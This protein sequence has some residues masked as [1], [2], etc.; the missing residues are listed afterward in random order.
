L[1]DLD[2]LKNRAVQLLDY[3]AR[4]EDGHFYIAPSCHKY[5]HQWSWDSSFHAI[6]NAR[7][8]RVDLAKAEIISLL[9]AMTPDGHL[10]HIIFRDRSFITLATRL[11][12]S[13][14][15]R[16]GHSP[17]L[18]PPVVA[19]AIQEV[20]RRSEDRDFLKETLPLLE[21]HFIWLHAR[22]RFG[23]SNLISILSPWESGLDHKP[24]FDKL[25]GRCARLPLGLYFALYGS[26]IRL[27]QL[28]FDRDEIV[29]KSLFNVQDVMFN[30]IYALGLDALAELFAV[31]DDRSKAEQYKKHCDVVENDI[32]DECFDA[33][34][35]LYFDVDV[36]SGKMLMNPSITCLM[37]IA[38]RNIEKERCEQIIHHLQNINEFWLNFPIPSVPA[39]NP[40]F[41]A[42]DQRYL[43]RGPT[44][45]NTNWLIVE[46][47]R[48]HGYNELA[49]SIAEKSRELIWK[50]G[51]REYY[52]PFTGEGGGTR[53]FSWSTLAA[54]M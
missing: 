24:A 18:Q 54:V 43:W 27:I 29:K 39:S 10:P 47:L 14:W 42:E 30:T 35:G 1:A 9:S 33:G 53:D 20:W 6:V 26:E 44:W 52:N 49:D 5:P 4:N 8:G 7:L 28:N 3:N 45:I 13:Y 34:S 19:L 40:D 46:G 16:S 50:S 15:P 36:S 48:R 21:R 51:F 25:M 11:L 2:E 23:K 17:L 32:L 41:V 22:R 38:L 37:P 12:R 31:T